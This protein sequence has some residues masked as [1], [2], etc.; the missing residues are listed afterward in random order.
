MA[1]LFLILETWKCWCLLEHSPLHLPSSSES[2]FTY[3]LK[4]QF[5]A[6]TCLIPQSTLYFVTLNVWVLISLFNS[7]LYTELWL[8]SPC[9]LF[10][11]R[12][13][14]YW[15]D[16][17]SPF[18]P[19]FLTKTSQSSLTCPWQ[20]L[21]FSSHSSKHSFPWFLVHS[22]CSK[23]IFLNLYFLFSF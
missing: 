14:R 17:M 6:N 15:H 1:I 13:L 10:I 22:P 18:F 4:C 11:T 12:L 2:P 20:S 8:V 19:W 21:L 9:P 3:Q 23:E 7:V 5:V 16:V